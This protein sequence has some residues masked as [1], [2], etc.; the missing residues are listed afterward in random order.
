MTWAQYLSLVFRWV[1]EIVNIQVLD[2]ISIK[3]I[4][5]VP[6]IAKFLGYFIF[7]HNTQ[8]VQNVASSSRMAVGN[9]GRQVWSIHRNNKLRSAAM[10]YHPNFEY[11]ESNEYYGIRV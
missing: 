5:M 3:Y 9:A 1:F 8:V 11:G 2:G 10:S 6:F 7:G 4:I